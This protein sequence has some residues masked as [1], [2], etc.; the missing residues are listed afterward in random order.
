VGKVH[1]DHGRRRSRK[2]SRSRCNE[3]GC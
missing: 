2:V 1:A 3:P